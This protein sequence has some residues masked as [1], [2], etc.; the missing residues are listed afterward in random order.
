MGTGI[1]IL[2]KCI[3]IFFTDKIGAQRIL[4]GSMA[5]GGIFSMVF[6]LGTN[7]AMLIS[8]CTWRLFSSLVWSAAMLIVSWSH[9]PYR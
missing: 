3:G 9:E 5:A 1:Y 7:A 8:W 6:T 2:G 4:V